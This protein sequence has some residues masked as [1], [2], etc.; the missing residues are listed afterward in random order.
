[1]PLKLYPPRKSKNWSIRGTYLNVYVDRTSGTPDKK[2]AQKELK[3]IEFDIE[4]GRY[5]KPAGPTFAEAALKY[6]KLGKDNRFISN[7]VE[8]F[9]ETPLSLI[10]Q[11]TIDK[12]ADELY[13][14]ASPA[15]KNRQVYTPMSAILAQSK[16]RL[17]LTRP[18]GW[19][20]KRRLFWMTPEQVEKLVN[21]AYEKDAEFGLFLTFLFYTGV[22]LSEAL[23]A[24]IRELNL[25][26]SWLRI[27]DTKN[28]EPRLVHLPPTLVAALSEHPRGLDREGKIFRFGKNGRLYQWLNEASQASGVAIPDGVAFHAFRHT[29]AASMRRYAGLDTSGLVA[30]GAWK[31]R[32]AA[33]FYEHSVQSE[34][35]QRANMLP[36]IAIRGKLGE[37]C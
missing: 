5:A 3:K 1:M 11:E 35:A 37:N 16:I 24:Q 29:W 6:I 21:K 9:K 2:L 8:H 7:L 20:G 12:A 14:L 22:R 18:K 30:T 25:Q 31:S 28:G 13:P 19:N 23:D 27:L 36:Q 15:T 34:E 17:N 32:T 4:C 26:E 33:S 10:N